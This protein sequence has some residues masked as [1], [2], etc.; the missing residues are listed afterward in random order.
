VN[1][2]RKMHRTFVKISS[3]NSASGLEP[4]VEKV[5]DFASR[6]KNDEKIIRSILKNATYF[7][8]M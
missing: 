5:A 8:R 2:N 1:S 6:G 3:K 4:R 7:T